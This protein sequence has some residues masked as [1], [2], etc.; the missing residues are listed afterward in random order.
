ML[1]EYLKPWVFLVAQPRL[2]V[3]DQD[4]SFQ[5]LSF[6]PPSP[7]QVT[8]P[9]GSLCAPCT[10]L[11]FAHFL[12]LPDR[13]LG[14]RVGPSCEPSTAVWLSGSGQACPGAQRLPPTVPRCLVFLVQLLLLS[15]GFP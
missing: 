11:A 6:V 5:T 9:A 3:L 2:Q 4:C 15:S 14:G 10:V 7:L 8:L 12:G 13:R 1:W